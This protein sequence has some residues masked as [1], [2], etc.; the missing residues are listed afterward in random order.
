MARMLA[1]GRTKI[2]L[3][4]EKPS[5]PGAPTASELN[6]GHDAS[7]DIFH[8]DFNFTAQASTTA[9]TKKLTQTGNAQTPTYKQHVAEMTIYRGFSAEGGFEKDGDDKTAQILLE[10]HN[11]V[12]AYARRTDKWSDDE[13]EE[14]DEIYMGGEFTTDVPQQGDTE[15]DIKIRCVMLPQQVHDYITVGASGS[16]D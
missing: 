5:N 14:G 11:T 1:D 12:W 7:G 15:D 3:L 9:D 4:T 16:G 8:S 13:W 10:S 2:T 6:E